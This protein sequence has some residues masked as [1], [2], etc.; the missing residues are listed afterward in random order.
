MIEYV[1]TFFA[2]VGAGIALG[3]GLSYGFKLAELLEQL[4]KVLG[5]LAVELFSKLRGLF[6]AD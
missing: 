5:C 1:T 3:S 6:H 4:S 2:I